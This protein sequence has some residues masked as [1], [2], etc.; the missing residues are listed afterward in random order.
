M[1]PDSIRHDASQQRSGSLFDIRDPIRE[2]NSWIDRV[3][4]WRR[5][6]GCR[7]VRRGSGV[8]SEQDLDKAW[9]GFAKLVIDFT[10]SQQEDILATIIRRHEAEATHLI[11]P[12][13]GAIDAI[14]R[15][16][17]VTATAAEVTT[18]AITTHA[19]TRRTTEV[20]TGRTVTKATAT[21]EA[22]AGATAAKATR[23]AEIAARRT[24]TKVAPRRTVT[25]TTRRAEATTRRGTKIAARRAIAEIAARRT[26][27]KPTRG[28]T[29]PA[30]SA[31][32]WTTLQF[33]D[34][35]DEAPTRA[36]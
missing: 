21:T 20:T 36:I 1:L 7:W 6:G 2:A 11:K 18:R 35:C 26:V 22:T 9:F 16:A 33:R 3:G 34:P 4:S 31:T 12:L 23:R 24:V 32:A 14:G 27:A 15:P 29:K 5:C 13:H 28:A 25:K 17:G 10:S 19:A 8:F 30:R